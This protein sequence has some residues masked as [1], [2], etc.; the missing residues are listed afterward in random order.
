MKVAII[1]Q[2]YVGA[3]LGLAAS[4]A[5]H[6][7]YGIEENLNRIR[8]LQSYPYSIGN[9]SEV[10]SE[11]DVIVITVPT[12]IFSD[13]SPNLTYLERACTQITEFAKAKTLIVNEST[14]YPGTLRYFIKP[15]IGE[16]FYYASAPERV[17]PGNLDWNINNTPRVIGALDQVSLDLATN[18]YETFTS[19][20]QI[21][22]SAEVAEA[23]KILENTFRQVNIAL[24]NELA[25]VTKSL[26]ISA[27]EVVEAAN[28]KPFGF[29][30]FLP[31]VGVG[32][33]CIPVDPYYLV[34]LARKNN[35]S[36]KL[37]ETAN[38]I[39][40]SVPLQLAKKINE[41]FQ[42]AGKKIQIAGL[43]YKANIRDIRE[44]PSVELMLELRKLGAK[45][46]WNDDIIQFYDREITEPIQDADLG[47]ICTHH[48]NM[49]FTEWDRGKVKVLDL[50]LSTNLPYEKYL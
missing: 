22:S 46:I 18:F 45:V 21:V 34:A 50:S 44:S 9:S 29:M 33:H 49:N 10:I 15:R 6:I 19:E 4:S 30:K 43:A 24:V 14:S 31:S 28:T 37:V 40:K 1:G 2:G 48:K 41:E 23:S 39:N 27:H 47:I 36:V 17:D 20:I 13:G 16:I 38:N 8:E 11:V 35:V 3:S 25:A 7:V 42:I 32:G 5:G 26:G 12:P